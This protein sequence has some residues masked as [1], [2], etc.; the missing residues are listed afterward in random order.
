M[1]MAYLLQEVDEERG[2][3]KTLRLFAALLLR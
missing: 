2:E 3:G 1:A